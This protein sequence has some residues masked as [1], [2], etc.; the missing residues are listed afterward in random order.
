MAGTGISIVRGQSSPTASR[1]RIDGS[2]LGTGISGRGLCWMLCVG[3]NI[4]H[5]QS[6]AGRLAEQGCPVSD[7]HAVV[8][9]PSGSATAAAA[10]SA[11]SVAM[12]FDDHAAHARVPMSQIFKPAPAVVLPT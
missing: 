1:S 11:G 4:A 12:G 2:Y 5:A 7:I 3:I 8:E 9:V 10:A 6:A